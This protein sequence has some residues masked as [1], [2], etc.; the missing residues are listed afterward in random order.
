MGRKPPSESVRGNIAER[1]L[2]ELGARSA[3]A[4]RIVDKAPNNCDYLGLIHSVFPNA[5][6]IYM[7]RD[8]IDSSLSC[9]FQQFVT[10]LNFTM[11]LSDLA[12]YFREHRRLMAHW[13]AILPSG[14]I[15]DVPYEALIADQESW[16]RKILEFLGLE[17]D[18]RCLEFH[19]TKR[20]VATSSFWQVR[21]RIYRASVARWRNYEKF[22][23]PLLSMRA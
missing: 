8:P 3:D 10:A 2:R 5:R 20:P 16:T 18:E 15:L 19:K 6:I 1:Y 7:Q 9:Y 14:S 13:R 17:W 21:Q 22:I 11:D 12:H 4:S 23:E